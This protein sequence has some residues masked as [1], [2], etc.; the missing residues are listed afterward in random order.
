MRGGRR[1]ILSV[2]R[3]RGVRDK[4][5]TPAGSWVQVFRG[6]PRQANTDHNHKH[7]PHHNI[8]RYTKIETTTKRC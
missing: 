4:K 7:S 5:F 1:A 8:I 6:E 2:V 3:A